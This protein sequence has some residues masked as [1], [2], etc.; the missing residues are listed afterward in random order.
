MPATAAV[1]CARLVELLGD[2]SSW[3]LRCLASTG[4]TNADLAELAKAGE[5]AGLVLVADHQ[6]LGRGRFD[7]AWAS[8]P[9]SSVAVSVLL[10]PARAAFD[11]GWL[12]LLVGLAVADG[13]RSLGASERVSLKWPNDVLI[14][15]RK[16]CGILSER[17]LTDLGDAAICGFGINVS[18]NESELPVPH[19]TSLLLAGLS[20]DKDALLGAVLGR[21]DEL[22]GRW[23]AGDD[24]RAEYA[25]GC[26]T[27]GRPVR[28]HLD[29]QAPDAASVTGRAVGVGPNGEIMIDIDGVVETFSAGDVVHLR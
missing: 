20:T 3:R 11:W 22:A 10:R 5:P 19:A 12:S 24:L 28:V 7:R 17:V 18:M 8:P 29:E 14:D 23:D 13:I 27:I 25:A 6:E 16:V 4:S 9:G 15:E 2:Q 1:N 21:L 26:A